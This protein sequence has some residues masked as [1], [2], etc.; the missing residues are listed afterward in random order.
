MQDHEYDINFAITALKKAGWKPEK[1]VKNWLLIPVDHDSNNSIIA[2]YINPNKSI[3]FAR[4][5]MPIKIA[6]EQE[7]LIINFVN[8]ANQ[9]LA[10][11]NLEYNPKHQEVSCRS[12]LYFRK[13]GLN[14]QIIHNIVYEVLH[15]SLSYQE[16]L[17]NLTQGK[18][19]INDIFH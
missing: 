14:P 4:C 12:G 8:L 18:A 17:L 13:I 19:S 6:P 2:F 1:S 9:Q 16:K 11:S 10:I 3:L 5:T 7:S 15:N